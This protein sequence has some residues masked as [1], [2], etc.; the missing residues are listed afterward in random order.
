MKENDELLKENEDYSLIPVE[1]KD[2]AWGVRILKG[3][4]IETVVIF[5]AV[6]FNKI[7]DKLTFNFEVFESPD[8]NLTADDTALQQHCAKILEAIIVE[9]IEDGSVKL[10]DVIQ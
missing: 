1:G 8:S 9:G 5:G 7:K 10:N 2:D 4:F 6:G 3:P